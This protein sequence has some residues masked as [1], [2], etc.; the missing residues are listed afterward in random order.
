MNPKISSAAL[1][2]V[3]LPA[4][5][6]AQTAAPP[7]PSPERAEVREKV[8]VACA[9][10]IQKFCANN[11]RGKGATRACLDTHQNELT[12]ACRAARAERAALRAKE[13]G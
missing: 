8:R 3:L 6:L 1:L 7:T 10:D 9:A 5:A 12:P 11:E 2:L 13:K 4:A